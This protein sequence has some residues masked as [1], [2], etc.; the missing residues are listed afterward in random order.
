M[1]IGIQSHGACGMCHDFDLYEIAISPGLFGPPSR[2]L[3]REGAL[4]LF[5]SGKRRGR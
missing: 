4:L 1:S 5:C 3:F 2:F